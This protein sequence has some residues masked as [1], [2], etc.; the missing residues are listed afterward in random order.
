[1]HKYKDPYRSRCSPGEGQLLVPLSVKGEHLTQSYFSL[2]ARQRAPKDPDSPSLGRT[3][4]TVGYSDFDTHK[5][6]HVAALCE[7]YRM[8]T[9]GAWRAILAPEGGENV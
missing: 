5:A 1:M 7:K 2:G 6:A 8:P 3:G 9:E 4:T